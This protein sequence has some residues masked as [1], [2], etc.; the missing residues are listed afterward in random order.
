MRRQAVFGRAVAVRLVREAGSD[1]QLSPLKK[2]P[3]GG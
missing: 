2:Q 3:H 1:R